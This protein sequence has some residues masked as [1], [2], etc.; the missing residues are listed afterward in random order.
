MCL[1]DA[2][3]MANREDPDQIAERVW[4]GFRLFEHIYL[5]ENSW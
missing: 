5:S 2:D 4:S 3:G 1:S